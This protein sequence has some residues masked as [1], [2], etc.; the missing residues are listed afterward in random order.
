MKPVNKKELLADF[1]FDSHEDEQG[2]DFVGLARHVWA[3][4]WT[5]L[6]IAAACYLAATLY[7]ATL[8]PIYRTSALLKVEQKSQSVIG[9]ES[10]STAL[11]QGYLSSAEVVLMKSHRVLSAA[12]DE[13]K[14]GYSVTP[15]Y[16]KYIGKF[17]AD[18]YD[19]EGLAE[20]LFG[21]EEYAWGGEELEMDYF[22]LRGALEEHSTAWK[23]VA[24]ENRQYSLLDSSGEQVLTGRVGERAAA[25]YRDAK[26]ELRVNRLLARPGLVF[27]INRPSTIASAESLQGK[28]Q[29][30]PEG[31]SGY[32]DSGIIRL[33]MEGP[34]PQ[35]I[36]DVV[37]AVARNYV[38]KNIEDQSKEAEQT[39]EFIEGQLPDLKAKLDEAQRSL[40][41]SRKGVETVDIEFEMQNALTQFTEYGKEISELELKKEDLRRRFTESNPEVEV[42]TRQIE[43]IK[44]KRREIEKRLQAVPE[45]EWEFIQKTRDVELATNLYEVLLNKAQELRIAKAGMVGN[46][47]IIDKA[48]LRP[49]PVKPDKSR[50]RQMGLVIGLL[51]GFAWL[52]IRHL[53]HNKVTDPEKIEKETGLHVYAVIPH[54]SA[55]LDIYTGAIKGRVKRLGET[56]L[57]ACEKD[58]D[59]AVEALRSFRTSMRFA[60]KTA[61]DNVI[62]IGGP[63]PTIGK[64]FFA[65]NYAAI[66][67]KEG[68][69]VLLIDADMRKGHLHHY[70]GKEIK[71]GLSELIAND[72]GLE[73]AVHEVADNL[74]F[75]S[76]GERP[77]NPAELLGSAGFGNLFTQVQ[78]LYDLVII[79]TPPILAVTDASV[80]AQYGGQ[81]FVL[82][83]SGQHQMSEIKASISVFEKNGVSVTG[84]LF[85]D[86]SLDERGYGYGYGY[87][88]RYDYK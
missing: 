25:D 42:I 17:F 47:Q 22:R 2:I 84:L 29:V 14:L 65:S 23:L 7:A 19:G 74:F 30:S 70:M 76:C 27:S 11:G 20:P 53:L 71:P 39:L 9:V 75:V 57:L 8:T 82:L 49:W 51:L 64:S 1:V 16:L 56:R 45:R 66:A 18:R 21:L 40:Q 28:L 77:P 69:R 50:I 6:A 80:I 26:I 48:G 54:S 37:N 87:G 4:K 85:N 46:V 24:G 61:E 68:Q 5:I 58:N 36:T 13:L 15:R 83:R 62:I 10:V 67:A 35:K 43:R 55:E 63:S 33:S 31:G 60:M 41:Q 34:D 38:Q 79:D 73:E 78:Q 86:V 72:V 88:Y 12:I 52:Y 3:H 44:E 59:L 81:L 32:R